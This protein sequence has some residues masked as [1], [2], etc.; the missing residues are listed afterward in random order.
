MSDFAPVGLAS[1]VRV[2]YVGEGRPLNSAVMPLTTGVQNEGDS[3]AWH[4]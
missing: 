1:A 2:G 4:T 3:H